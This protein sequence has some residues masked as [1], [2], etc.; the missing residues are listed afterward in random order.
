M[1]PFETRAPLSPDLTPLGAPSHE[2]STTLQECP[3]WAGEGIGHQEAH[4]QQ[5]NNSGGV[6]SPDQLLWAPA[7]SGLR[8][9]GFEVRIPINAQ[10]F[11]GDLWT[12]QR[13]KGA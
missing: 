13:T 1:E 6:K 8:G 3:P 2:F 5:P 12:Q 9:H 7:S 10:D 11:G 4:A